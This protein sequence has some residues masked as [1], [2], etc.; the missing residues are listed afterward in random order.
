M[1]TSLF[2]LTLAAAWTGLL[3]MP[4]VLDRFFTRG[5]G[6][7]VGYPDAPRAQSPWAQRLMGAHGNAVENLVVFATL[8]LIAHAAGMGGAPL[9][10]T[11]AM[12]YFWARVAHAVVMA[13][14][15]P[16]VRTVAFLAGFAAQAMVAWQLL[17]G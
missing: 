9:V 13:L 6:A 7:T 4:Y 10:A 1:D 15:L 3:W 5:I 12:L 14:G 11:A 17:I 2:Y 16:W 8:V